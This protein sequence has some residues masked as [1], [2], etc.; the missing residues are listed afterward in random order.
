VIAQ[1]EFGGR[2][3]FE[4]AAREANHRSFLGYQLVRN[5]LVPCPLE[6]YCGASEL[7]A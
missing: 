3:I 1:R 7:F 2:D 4:A 6:P 5:E